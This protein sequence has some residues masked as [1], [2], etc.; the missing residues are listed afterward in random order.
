MERIALITKS[1]KVNRLIFLLSLVSVVMSFLDLWMD[2]EAGFIQHF[3]AELVVFVVLLIICYLTLSE[4]ND[5]DYFTLSA[6]SEKIESLHYEKRRNELLSK[7]L[8]ERILKQFKSWGFTRAEIEVAT[9]LIK[10]FSIKEIAKLRGIADKTV[11]EQS[12]AI[13]RKSGIHSRYELA[14]FFIEDIL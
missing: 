11:R 2:L 7:S 10:G 6:L 5:L 1:K 14:A 8:Y 4:K 3:Y 12:S 13:Y 9:L